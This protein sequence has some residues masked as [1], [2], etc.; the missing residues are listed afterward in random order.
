MLKEERQSNIRNSIFE[1]AHALLNI[2]SSSVGPK[3][4]D[5]ML[6]KQNKTTVTNDGATILKFFTDNPIHL[7]LSN[8]SNAQVEKCGDGTTSVIILTCSLLNSL[9]KLIDMNIH[10]SI[11]CDHLEKARNIA[12]DYIEW[13]KI[14]NN[15]LNIFNTVITT[16][17]SKVV[18]NAVEMANASIKAMEAVNYEKNKIRILK[19]LGGSIDDVQ[20]YNGMLFDSNFK[21][22]K[23][24]VK[25]ALI[26]FCISAP[27]TNMDSKILVDNPLLMEHI[28]SDERKYILEI[29]KKIKMTGCQLLI[30][31]K[32]ILRDSLSEL[33]RH[34]LKKLNIL[35]LESVDRKEIENI[36]AALNIEPV[37]DI[38]LFS[39]ENLKE[40]EIQNTRD[41]LEIKGF[42]SSIV[43]NGCDDLIL[44][45]VERSLNDA[46]CVVNCMHEEN[47]IVPG[48][49]AI[50]IAI[51]KKI[52]ESDEG[53]IFINREIS[54]GF[55]SIPYFLARNA[56]HNPVEA[57]SE[58]RN[59]IKDEPT[60]G[61]SV[62]GHN[63]ND[64]LEDD[65][66]VQPVS[67]TKSVV[68]LAI[69]T[70]SYM[71]KIDDIL[72]SRT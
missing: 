72:P 58:L 60:Y 37:S 19:K 26:Q 69:E 35:V 21:T 56:G 46:L 38:N 4:L 12:I 55:E 44:D 54:K 29:C 57:V 2:L 36:S 11:I 70:V 39:T 71:L 7:F 17:N 24:T 6:I 41:F 15:N 45:E 64:M 67:I 66:V 34:F 22:E 40:V 65:N 25:C 1:S 23:R 62:R 30:I 13:V 5:K 47:F 16:L 43:L 33:G 48:G 9:K 42:G 32:S 68:N 51:S 18:G 10:P 52:L 8:V 28:I 49:G 27:K 53:N 31:Q 14:P 63:I 3:G 20:F 59:I 61:V 50:E